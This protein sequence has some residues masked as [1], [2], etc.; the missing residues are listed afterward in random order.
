MYCHTYKFADRK[1][2][3][4]N[5]MRVLNVEQTVYK[6]YVCVYDLSFKRVELRLN[7]EING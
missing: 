7:S 3:K 6:M 5:V 1:V 2:R 4:K